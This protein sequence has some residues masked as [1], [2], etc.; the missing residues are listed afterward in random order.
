VLLEYFGKAAPTAAYAAL[1]KAHRLS[2]DIPEAE[3]ALRQGVLLHGKSLPFAIEEAKIAAADRNWPIAETRWRA[4]FDEYAADAPL[5]AYV[6]LSVA[7]RSQGKYGEAEAAIESARTRHRKGIPIELEWAEIATERR[8][9]TEAISRWN[10]LLNL[11]GI[12]QSEIQ[13]RLGSVHRMDGDTQAAKACFDSLPTLIPIFVGY[14]PIEEEINPQQN[15]RPAAKGGSLCVHLHLFHLSMFELFAEKLR[16][17]PRAFT[18]VVSLP[19][20][21]DPAYWERGFTTAVP[22]AEKLI[23]SPVANRGR[24]V[25]P[26]MCTFRE[27][28]QSHDLFLHLHSKLSGGS[29]GLLWTEFLLN[30]VLGSEAVV[31]RILQK[32]ED[33]E[34]G[35]VYPPYFRALVRQPNWGKNREICNELYSRLFSEPLPGICPDY[36]AGS[37]FWARS[38]YLKPL[39]DLGLTRGRFSARNRTGR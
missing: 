12:D 7:C 29:K 4:L 25:L 38:S 6:G 30:S 35:L 17:I 16:L 15:H 27:V 18:L 13:L 19:A 3:A 31:D 37:F 24:D 22:R 20:E 2:K 39:F 21:A 11:E 9:W 14:G 34:L 8:D 33:E 5:D 32:F 10:A 1:A 26:W 23:I 36:P 28:V